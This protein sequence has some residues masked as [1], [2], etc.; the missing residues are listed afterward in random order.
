MGAADATIVLGT[1]KF[2]D[3]IRRVKKDKKLQYLDTICNIYIYM[4]LYWTLNM[5]LDAGTVCYTNILRIDLST[6]TRSDP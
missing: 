4:T 1:A 5:I 6:T 3:Q 2:K